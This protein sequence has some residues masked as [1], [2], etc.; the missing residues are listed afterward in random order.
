MKGQKTRRKQDGGIGNTKRTSKMKQIISNNSINRLKKAFLKQ[1]K[2]IKGLRKVIAEKNEE[3]GKLRMSRTAV[4]N[5]K[6][7][8]QKSC[9]SSVSIDIS[10]MKGQKT[11]R[12]QVGYVGKSKRCKMTSKNKQ[13]LSNNSLNRMDEAFFEVPSP[14]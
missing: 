7:L 6:P 11:K 10:S 2:L 5:E 13:N 3:I 12:K 9:R 4:E 1:K 14:F 8:V